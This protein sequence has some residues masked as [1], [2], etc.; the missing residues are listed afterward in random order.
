[1]SYR[2]AARKDYVYPVKLAVLAEN[3]SVLNYTFNAK[4]KRF[5]QAAI[6]EIK[7][8]VKSDKEIAQKTMCGWEAVED[9]G[10]AAVDFNPE[11]LDRLLADNGVAWAIARAWFESVDKELIKN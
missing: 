1:M 2:I 8:T 10:G 11:S 4:F 9:D 7:A 6:D 3:G 5:D